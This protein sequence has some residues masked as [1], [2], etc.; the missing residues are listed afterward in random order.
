MTAMAFDGAPPV[1]ATDDKGQLL[2]HQ[3][4]FKVPV[5]MTRAA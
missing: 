3:A 4:G 2:C 1:T 5:A